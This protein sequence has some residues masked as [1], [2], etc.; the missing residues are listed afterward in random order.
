M[1]V[2]SNS[3]YRIMDGVKL[4]EVEIW[5][6]NGVGNSTNTCEVEFVNDKG[7]FGGPGSSF[8]DCAL[9][10]SNIAHVCARPQKTSL[11]GNWINIFEDQSV[12]STTNQ[13]L[14]RITAPQGSVVDIVVT[15]ALQD[16]DSA[17]AVAGSVSGATPGTF[18]YRY[19]DSTTN[20]LFVPISANYI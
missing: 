7:G 18:Y 16:N 8:S 15:C 6:C 17:T 5:S 13:K 14:F 1:A 4:K 10:V 11:A 2:T 20:Q 12:G 3:A 19:L 9:G